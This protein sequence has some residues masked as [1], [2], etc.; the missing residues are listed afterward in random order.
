M[1]AIRNVP[2]GPG[3]L[4]ST[5]TLQG[6]KIGYIYSVMIKMADSTNVHGTTE[7]RGRQNYMKNSSAIFRYISAD[8]NTL[9]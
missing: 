9:L 3:F 5:E 8:V 7:D 1:K 2:R 6:D 4:F